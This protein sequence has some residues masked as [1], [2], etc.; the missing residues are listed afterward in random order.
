MNCIDYI[1]YLQIL[2]LITKN[3]FEKMK[4]IAG[5]LRLLLPV[6]EVRQSSNGNLISGDSCL[7]HTI[8]QGSY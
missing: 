7:D 6:C 1:D 2:F 3:V 8:S 5:H 4:I